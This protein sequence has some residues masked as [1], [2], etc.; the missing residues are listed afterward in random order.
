MRKHRAGSG[1]RH[2][3]ALES[4]LWPS[5]HGH[6]RHHPRTETAAEGGRRKIALGAVI[7][8]LDDG[9]PWLH[10]RFFWSPYDRVL[11][12][13]HPSSMR[14]KSG[15]RSVQGHGSTW[16][17]DFFSIAAR[18]VTRWKSLG[19]KRQI[20]SNCS[21][22]EMIGRSQADPLFGRTQGWQTKSRNKKC[23]PSRPSRGGLTQS[24]KLQD[25]RARGARICQNHVVLGSSA[26]H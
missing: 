21:V 9:S 18:S 19:Q 13:A 10:G 24:K 7:V 3:I 1:L 26:P 23:C 6:R 5:K 12:L 17:K 25:R 11:G 8:H 2:A 14:F 20:L 16:F 4:H 22:L 15:L